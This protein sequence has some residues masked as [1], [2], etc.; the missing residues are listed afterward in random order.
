MTI[1]KIL[2]AVA[3]TA[4]AVTAMATSVFAADTVECDTAYAGDWGGVTGVTYDVLANYTE[5]GAV[6]TVNFNAYEDYY[7]YFLIAPNDYNNSWARLY[8]AAAGRADTFGIPLKND[9]TEDELAAATICQQD[10]GFMILNP[11]EKP[12]SVTFEVTAEAIKNIVD[13]E[14]SLGFQV[15]G[16]SFKSITIDAPAAGEPGDGDGSSTVDTDT[17]TGDGNTDGETN[18]DTGVT[19]VA[20]LAVITLAGAAIVASKKR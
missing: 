15:Y 9:L 13:T 11:T 2:A 16:V 12:M 17:S 6:V 10:D 20:A 14:S 18:A 19:P 8:D 7:E 4:V 5:T 1:K 3:A